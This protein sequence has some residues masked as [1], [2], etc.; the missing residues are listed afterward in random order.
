ML[1][2]SI[3]EKVQRVIVHVNIQIDLCYRAQYIRYK[4]IRDFPLNVK[5]NLRIKINNELI[6]K[7]YF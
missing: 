4:L 7:C 2:Y 5:N 1:L 6:L 3:G